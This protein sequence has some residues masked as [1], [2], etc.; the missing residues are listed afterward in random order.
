MV[1]LKITIVSVLQTD[2]SFI[3]TSGH[4]YG[5]PRDNH[6]L[7]LKT[8]T[9]FKYTG[10]HNCYFLDFSGFY[11]TKHNILHQ[12]QICHLWSGRHETNHLILCFIRNLLASANQPS[13]T[14][15][16]VYWIC[17]RNFDAAWTSLDKR[18]VIILPGTK[19]WHVDKYLYISFAT[20]TAH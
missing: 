13:N 4:A 2:I 6:S 16:V 17:A 20:D 19:P 14:S 7:S 5:F 1:L 18:P 15:N 12:S 10:D 9:S 8:G 11:Y 3:K